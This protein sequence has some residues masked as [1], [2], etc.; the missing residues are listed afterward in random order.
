MDNQMELDLPSDF[1]SPGGELPGPDSE[2][3]QEE[4]FASARAGKGKGKGRG[5]GRVQPSEAGSSNS[6]IN[7]E[8]LGVKKQSKTHNRRCKGC[9]LY[10]R[11]EAMGSKSCFCIIRD[12]LRLDSLTRVARAQGKLAWIS[13]VRRD[14]EKV[15]RVL[16][17]YDEL[18]GGTGILKTQA[19]RWVWI[20]KF[21]IALL[22]C[23]IGLL[24]RLR[25]QNLARI[26]DSIVPA[27]M[28]IQVLYNAL[29][30]PSIPLPL[31]NPSTIPLQSFYNPPTIIPQTL[32]RII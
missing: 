1:P 14:E 15:Q 10:F 13:E 9:S 24:Q 25:G 22:F 17:K 18:T 27:A 3:E 19:G 30:T 29:S 8:L 23:W 7:K 2:E 26:Y 4:P 28:S 20:V 11:A 12:K 16:R 31:Y 5:R 32:Q 6:K 21:V